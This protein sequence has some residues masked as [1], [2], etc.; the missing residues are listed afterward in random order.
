MD[1]VS[2]LLADDHPLFLRGLAAAV[3]IRPQLELVAT[4]RD[5]REA[6]AAIRELRPA[7]AVL[8]LEMPGLRGP[9][10]A[11]AVAR[12]ELPTRVLMISARVDGRTVHD[13]L[14]AGAAGYL[15]KLTREE[16]VCDAI[17]AVARG[18]VVL[19]PELQLGLVAAI[20]SH[21]VSAAPRLSA[22]EGEVLRLLAD[23]L[24]APEVAAALHLSVATVRTHLRT[25]FEKLDVSTQ[26]GAVAAAMRSGLLE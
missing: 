12:D 7:V 5:G 18:S 23:G 8:D 6:L 13:A 20:R 11:R 3:R 4:A 10:V 24:S 17:A 26:A 25:L 14:G 21:A 2:V 19:P 9:E 16:D 15:S 22:R 1:R